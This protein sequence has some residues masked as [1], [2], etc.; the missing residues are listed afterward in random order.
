MESSLMSVRFVLRAFFL[1]LSMDFEAQRIG[2]WEELGFLVHVIA[3][4]GGRVVDLL[5]QV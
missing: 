2:F 1:F 4:G 3:A 5:P